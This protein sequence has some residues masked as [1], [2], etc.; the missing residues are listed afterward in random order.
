MAGWLILIIG[1]MQGAFIAEKNKFDQGAFLFGY[2]ISLF[3]LFLISSIQYLSWFDKD[4]PVKIRNTVKILVLLIYGL[5]L[6]AG[7]KFFIE[8]LNLKHPYFVG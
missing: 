3:I 7:I 1:F 6:I 8:L 4:R 2:V 5:H